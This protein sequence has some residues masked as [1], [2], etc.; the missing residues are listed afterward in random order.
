MGFE[1]VKESK[2][3]MKI[4]LMSIV[5]LAK[6]Q[7]IASS[8]TTHFNSIFSV[9]SSIITR[10]KEKKKD[11][12]GQRGTSEAFRQTFNNSLLLWAP[13]AVSVIQIQE[14]YC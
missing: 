14:L 13:K 12:T 9:I 2:S 6:V 8:C 10:T 3:K 5:P 7:H 4:T 11:Q 1:C